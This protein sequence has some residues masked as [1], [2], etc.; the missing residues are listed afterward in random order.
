LG[1]WWILLNTSIG[2]EEID[3]KE[4][5]TQMNDTEKETYIVPRWLFYAL[6]IVSVLSLFYVLHLTN[7]SRWRIGISTAR[8][9]SSTSV[10]TI[11][12]LVALV[13]A[14]WQLVRVCQ[15]WG[16]YVTPIQRKRRY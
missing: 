3:M 2:I 5:T 4:I 12:I 6:I 1:S 14:G 13:V 7:I 15:R 10:I 11:V 16:R 8:G 9:T